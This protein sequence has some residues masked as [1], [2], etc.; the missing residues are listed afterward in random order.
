MFGEEVEERGQR[1][2]ILLQ[3]M[4]CLG[5]PRTALA[6]ESRDRLTRLLAGLGVLD[7]VQGGLARG[8]SRRGNLSRMLP[9]LW[10]LCLR[11]RLLKLPSLS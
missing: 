5:I 10:T 7:L 9:S 1:V 3:R 8:W 4:D 6:G 11:L 2:G